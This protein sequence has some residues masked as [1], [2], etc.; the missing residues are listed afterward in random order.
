VDFKGVGDLHDNDFD[1][2]ERKLTF[3][4]LVNASDTAYPLASSECPYAI[5][6]YPSQQFYDS[7]VTNSPISITLIVGG[8]FIFTAIMFVLYDRLVERR[9]QLLLRKAT[10]SSAI[11]ASLFP[12]TIRDQLMAE[13]EE[14]HTKDK[15]DGFRAPNHRLKSFL[16]NDGDAV[17]DKSQKPIADLFPHCS[18][19]FADV[20]CLWARRYWKRDSYCTYLSQLRRR[21]FADFGFHRV[22]SLHVRFLH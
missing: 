5:R 2:Y 11:L 10:Q 17:D 22:R 4:D 19:L 20:S 12:K 15:G 6:V 16:S 1:S 3:A 7:Y 18:V 21:F 14:N 13:A 8:I 9:Q